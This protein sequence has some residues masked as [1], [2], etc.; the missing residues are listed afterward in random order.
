MKWRPTTVVRTTIL[1][2]AAMLLSHGGV[3][4]ATFTVDSDAD[5][6]DIALGDG[7]A[8]DHANPDSSRVT[9]R[10]A[11]EEANALAGSDTVIVAIETPIELS[12]GAIDFTDSRTVVTG[13]AG[14]TI[15][16]VDNP[17]YLPTLRILADSCQVSGVTLRRSR[18]SGIEINARANLIG[19]RLITERVVLIGNAIDLS[20][21]AAIEI[22]GDSAIG[23][24]IEGCWIGLHGNGTETYGNANGVVITGGASGNRV[25]NSA[26]AGRNLISGNHGWGVSV[27]GGATNNQVTGNYIGPDITGDQGPGNDS[28]GVLI[29]AAHGNTVGGNDFAAGNLISGN[30][31][32]GVRLD[33]P[34]VTGCFVTGNFIGTEYSGEMSL[35]NLGRGV[36]LLDGAHDNT[37][38]GDGLEDGNF[39]SGNLRSGLLLSGGGTQ[40]NLVIGNAI[41]LRRDG[42]AGVSNGGAGG[43]GIR[44][45]NGARYNQIGGST[46][47]ARN[48]VS[49]NV[50]CGIHLTGSGT[51]HNA[52]TG[53]LIGTTGSGVSSLFNAVGVC[54]DSGA[55]YNA[56]GGTTS[57]EGNVISGNR[58]QYFPSGAG[59]Q[60]TGS[61]TDHNVVVGNLIGLDVDGVR[62]L[63]NGSAG[64]L[65]GDGAR[66]NRIGGPTTAE[67]NVISGNGSI[68]LSL[69]LAAGI[70]L[71]GIGTE[72]NEIQ[73]NVL[74]LSLS[75]L[76]NV[77]NQGHGIGLF[78][79]A[80]NN[81]IGGNSE[82]Y[83]N[84]ITVSALHGIVISDPAS[85]GNL[86][87]YNRIYDNDSLGID[88]TNSAQGNVAPPVLAVALPEIVGGM[89]A[90]PFGQVDVYIAKPD[91]S[92]RGE[93]VE[94]VGTATANASGDFDVFLSGVTADDTLT[95][96]ATD[97][98]N[99][100]SVFST[101]ISADP[102]SV[103]GIIGDDILPVRFTLEQNY[104]NPF[105]PETRIVYGLP[106]RSDVTIDILNILGRTVRTLV[107]ESQAAGEYA[108]TWDGRDGQNR[109]VASGVYFYRLVTGE[110]TATRK[111][112]LIR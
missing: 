9:L 100:S 60:I 32:D 87:R 65:I 76:S 17:R 24:V 92:R 68:E 81:T 70:H 35:R 5:S 112:L 78:S 53:N 18:G 83:G 39:I 42:Y 28:G 95:A 10:A 99:N 34:D 31:G 66:Y 108:V 86:V 21:A 49:G 84:T 79:G 90:P 12:L 1:I 82:A 102:S 25:G 74:G 15:D 51:S 26:T 47:A 6:H 8:A 62:A 71:F 105:N 40:S 61:G 98:L 73:G 54:I 44:V 4:A 14:A 94:L 36:A 75:G 46:I 16:G 64:V 19:G 20:S 110:Y 103:V 29:T 30:G 45:E 59:V 109:S 111:M 52:I 77:P 58:S 63:P 41:G 97:T 91:P 67:R 56:I 106:R 37:I 88:I 11:I 89:G 13:S 80:S 93:G 69:G 43:D 23:N 57:G 27:S 72:Y 7:L 2:A 3:F 96:I 33:G 38:G 85:H 50:N 107:D 22:T 48:Y 101:I 55:Q 104:P